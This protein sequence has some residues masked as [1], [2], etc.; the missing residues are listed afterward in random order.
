[1]L[2][3]MEFVVLEYRN[4]ISWLPHGPAAGQSTNWSKSQSIDFDFVCGSIS[5]MRDRL[6]ETRTLVCPYFSGS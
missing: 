3:G 2:R 6:A 1:M 5:E 4:Q